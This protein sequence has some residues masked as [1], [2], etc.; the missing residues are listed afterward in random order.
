M[1]GSVAKA[2]SWAAATLLLKTLELL[3]RQTQLQ[4]N[5]LCDYYTSSRATWDF[6]KMSKSLPIIHGKS[7]TYRLS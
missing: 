1:M 3:F 7:K 6:L 2:G 5:H 4:Q